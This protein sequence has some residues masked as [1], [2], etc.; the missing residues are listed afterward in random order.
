MFTQTEQAGSSPSFAPSP[1]ARSR[2][3][4]PGRHRWRALAIVAGLGLAVAAGCGGGKADPP[5]PLDPDR[6][7]AASVSGG[8][9]GAG[10]SGGAAGQAGPGVGGAAADAAAGGTGAVGGQAGG[11]DAAADQ[12]TVTPEVGSDRGR[13]AELDG[14]ISADASGDAQTEGGDGGDDGAVRSD[15]SAVAACGNR[16][17]D[18]GEE[19]DNGNANV[20]GDWAAKAAVAPAVICNKDCKV[21]HKYCG[22]KLT[23][24]GRE[25]C[26]DGSFNL[27][28]DYSP[29]Q[30]PPGHAF[31]YACKKVTHFCGDHKVDKGF[32]Q[33]DPQKPAQAGVK[34]CSD[35]CQDLPALP[36]V[37]GDGMVTPPETCDNGA[38]NLDEATPH[39]PPPTDPKAPPCRRTSCTIVPFCGD[40]AVAAGEKCD[41]GK[42]NVDGDYSA[43]PP[44]GNDKNVC[45]RGTCELVDYC[46]DGKKNGPEACDGKDTPPGQT[47][48][49]NCQLG[50]PAARTLAPIS[51][52]NAQC[53]GS[54]VDKLK[55]NQAIDVSCKGGLA[56]VIDFGK[57]DG[58]PVDDD[59]TL[60]VSFVKPAGQ[61]DPTFTCGAMNLPVPASLKLPKACWN[62]GQ[63]IKLTIAN[64]PAGCVMLASAAIA[65]AS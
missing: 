35:K 46:G 29:V 39:A 17:I 4:Q 1:S 54:C 53:G 48:K 64:P 59:V 18:P 36:G 60:D 15:A 65:Y 63:A 27:K 26:D 2:H 22:D 51:V 58:A 7:D 8:R 6:S 34:G 45:R 41:N 55:K 37:C 12:A 9:G 32:E 23:E 47:C 21:V 52:S 20:T 33:C 43:A 40:G 16:K 13:D 56:S 49:A 31:C 24:P 30:P 11:G 10:A 50:Q 44:K 5:V 42:N 61:A 3:G 25:E 14:V 19:C 38:A 62:N 28:D 57:L